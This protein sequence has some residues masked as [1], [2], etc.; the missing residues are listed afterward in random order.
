MMSVG[1]NLETAASVAQECGIVLPEET[2]LFVRCSPILQHEE[3]NGTP[4]VQS[5]V[6]S[7]SAAG[8]SLDAKHT[9]HKQTVSIVCIGGILTI[10]SMLPNLDFIS[11]ICS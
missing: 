11:S 6:A 1:D 8:S 3:A 10:K 2:L 9:L 4:S 7:G 5:T